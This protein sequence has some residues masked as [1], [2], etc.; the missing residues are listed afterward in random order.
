[1]LPFIT[2]G[3]KTAFIV[4]Y[5]LS[6]VKVSLSIIP[7]KD[8]TQSCSFLKGF[9]IHANNTL[10]T[11][12]VSQT[13]Q[14]KFDF[15]VKPLKNNKTTSNLSFFNYNELIVNFSSPFNQGT[16]EFVVSS[17]YF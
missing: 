3:S 17:E 8:C 6:L 13:F 15:Q 2:I 1:M 9:A 7:T 11:I 4:I 14:I 16:I 10:A 5:I 12:T